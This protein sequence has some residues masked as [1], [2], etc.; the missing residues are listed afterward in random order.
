MNSKIK[1]SFSWEKFR[2]L[3]IKHQPKTIFYAQG[4]AP[5][6]TPPI[7]LRLTFSG[8]GI[9]YVFVDTARGSILRRT[10]IPI[11][12]DKHENSCIEEEDVKRFITLQLGR[13]DINIRSFELMGGY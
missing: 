9:Q 8:K 13:G 11:R 5:L 10:K 3:L 4:K 7:E 12:I 6:S 2:E 1:R